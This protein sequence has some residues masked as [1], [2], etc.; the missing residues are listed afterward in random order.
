MFIRRGKCNKCSRCCGSFN[1]FAGAMSDFKRAGIQLFRNPDGTYRCS[2]IE[3][4]LCKIQKNKPKACKNAPQAPFPWACGYKFIEIK[5]PRKEKR[6]TRKAIHLLE[7]IDPKKGMND[8]TREILECG[9][10]YLGSVI[11]RTL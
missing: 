11:Y 9:R 4:N 1:L 8:E 6:A 5:Q 7:E 3:G 2:M 10:D